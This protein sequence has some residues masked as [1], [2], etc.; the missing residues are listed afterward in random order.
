MTRDEIRRLAEDWVAA[1]NAHD[2]EAFIIVADDRFQIMSI[3]SCNPI[4]GQLPN[5]IWCHVS[6]PFSFEFVCITPPTPG[7]PLFRF[8]Q[9]IRL[10]QCLPLADM[11]VQTPET[12]YFPPYPGIILLSGLGDLYETVGPSAPRIQRPNDPYSLPELI[13]VQALSL[14]RMTL[15]WKVLDPIARR[16]NRGIF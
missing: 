12:P 13:S 4:L 14:L 3:P 7:A 15:A 11:D 16:R 10:A 9:C 6:F 8:S 2:L 1:W 5:L